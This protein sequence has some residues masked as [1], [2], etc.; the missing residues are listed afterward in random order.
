MDL[1]IKKFAERLLLEGTV[2][3]QAR[4]QR[5]LLLLAK[6]LTVSRHRAELEA[7]KATAGQRLADQVASIGGS[8]RFVIG[9]FVFLLLWIL[10]NGGAVARLVPEAAVDPYPFI[11]LNLIL[12]MLAAIQAPI[13][14]MSQNRQAEKDRQ[15]ADLDYE[16]NLKAELEILAMHDKLDRLR[17]EQIEAMLMAQRD[18]TRDIAA[19]LRRVELQV[20]QAQSA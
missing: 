5:V 18:Q 9:F 20:E 2:A 3:L 10:L 11:F 19:I 6:R 17:S 13:I 15:R 7:G 4:D 1:E 12:S 14:M 16:I 8:W